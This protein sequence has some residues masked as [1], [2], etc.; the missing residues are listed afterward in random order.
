VLQIKFSG[1]K[2]DSMMFYRRESQVDNE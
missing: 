1:N 2:Y